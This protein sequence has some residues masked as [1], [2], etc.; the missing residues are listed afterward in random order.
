MARMQGTGHKESA[1]VRPTQQWQCGLAEPCAA[2]PTVKG[3]CPHSDSSCIPQRSVKASRKRLFILLLSAAVAFFILLLGSKSLYSVLSPGPLSLGHAEVASCKDCH[4]ATEESMSDWVHKAFTLNSNNDD[5]KCLNCHEL[6]VNAFSPHSTVSSNLNN[7][8]LGRQENDNESVSS[9]RHWRISAA[10]KINSIISA[11]G[12]DI[13]CSSCHREHKGTFAPL[14]DF[15]PQECHSCH[16][17]TFDD[18]ETGHPEYSQFPHTR[19]TRINFDHVAH[20]QNH[21]FD[22]EYFDLAP[23]GCK[24]CHDTDQSGEWMLSNNFEASCS[25]CHLSEII[26]DNRASA[27]GLAVLSVPEIDT[28]TLQS[29]GYNIGYWPR[30]ADGQITPIMQALLLS[31]PSSEEVLPKNLFDLTNASDEDLD[32][33]AK[34]AW[35]IK[36]LFY[37]IQLGGAK[38]LSDRI[39]L[40]TTSELDQTTLNKLVASLPR[41]TLINNQQEWFPDLIEEV[42]AFR[43]GEVIADTE[44][45]AAKS[46]VASQTEESFATKSEKQE[47][48][49]DDD[50]IL[51]DDDDILSDDDEGASMIAAAEVT[52]ADNESWAFSG[53]WYRDGSSIRYRPVGHADQ[54]FRSWL[55]VSSRNPQG[56]YSKVF[57]SLV[58]DDS[59]GSCAKCHSVEALT[60]SNKPAVQ[61]A[62]PSVVQEDLIAQAHR[63]HW[64]SFKPEDVSVDFNRFSHVSHFSLMNDDGC[65]SCHVLNESEVENKSSIGEVF[66]SSFMTMDRQTCVQC[67]QQGRAPDNCLTCHNYHVEPLMRSIN[68]ISDALREKNNE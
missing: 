47:N 59:V 40:S 19:A 28:A 20:L 67:H 30:W 11:D 6:G 61:S 18:L 37:D 50:D 25:S 24:Q 5:Q 63:V 21:F 53:G 13:S 43:K 17:V 57:D 51:S 3:L 15:N 32:A 4:A 35:R 8:G 36:E 31:G 52:E 29:K 26:G 23:E 44:F 45:N 60:L 7:R 58:R 12:E 66:V 46:D 27:K 22:D 38:V 48:T 14:D 9:I 34:L 33:A 49:L 39:K 64:D 16:K 56:P 42:R 41:D 65:S 62:P 10:N 68:Q 54:F 2:G 1:Y 55:E